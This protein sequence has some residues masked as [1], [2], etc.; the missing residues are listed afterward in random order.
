MKKKTKFIIML[1]FVI[2]FW[3]QIFLIAS[4][5]FPD[6][7]IFDIRY[8]YHKLSTESDSDI[9][10]VDHYNLYNNSA[11][12]KI[13]GFRSGIDLEIK[14]CLLVYEEKIY[15]ITESICDKCRSHLN[16][17]AIGLRDKVVQT[18][19]LGCFQEDY[20][21]I[22]LRQTTGRAYA[23][24]SDDLIFVQ[25]SSRQ[26]AFSITTSKVEEV[27]VSP[28]L[29]SNFACVRSQDAK[30]MSVTRGDDTKTITL[31]D[32]EESSETADK[33]I[34]SNRKNINLSYYFYEVDGKLYFFVNLYNILG[35][36]YPTVFEYDFDTDKI[37]YLYMCA[38]ENHISN[39]RIAVV[40]YYE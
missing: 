35:N 3:L 28:S 6:G 10:I 12:E 8:K 25:D 40:P 23:I 39:G 33:I 37:S 27:D 4:T 38:S 30:S 18:T 36:A 32:F 5:F 11:N 13:D 31:K 1:V 15:A 26:I 21:S 20:E 14:E 2:L 34:D 24:L 22:M 19:D 7:G 9:F 29:P 16:V 17:S